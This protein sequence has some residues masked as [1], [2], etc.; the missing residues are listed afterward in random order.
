[1]TF[2]EIFE[3]EG[4]YT[5]NSFADG[6]ALKIEI[7]TFGVYVLSFVNYYNI[8]VITPVVLNMQI[9]DNLV[10]KNY[11]RV[12]TRYQLFGKQKDKLIS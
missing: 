8:D 10:N 7:D 4:L 9:T 1:M 5:A 3:E 11:K 2:I 12:L 6:V